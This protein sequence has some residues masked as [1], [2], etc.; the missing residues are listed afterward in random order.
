MQ[1]SACLTLVGPGT[2]SSHH[3]L[4]TPRAYEPY[5]GLGLPLTGPSLSQPAYSCSIPSTLLL[6]AKTRMFFKTHFL[7]PFPDEGM[8]QRSMEGPSSNTGFLNLDSNN[9]EHLNP[10]EKED[11]ER[12]T[13]APPSSDGTYLN[14]TLCDTRSQGSQ[15]TALRR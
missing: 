9:R 1:R 8:G 2:Q 6:A 7:S 13:E 12:F 15:F 10:R 4:T 3:I 14:G 5:Q 11:T